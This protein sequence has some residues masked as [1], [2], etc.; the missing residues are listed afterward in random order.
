MLIKSL[1][2]GLTVRKKHP[3]V[4]FAIILLSLFYLCIDMLI[5]KKIKSNYRVLMPLMVDNILL[6]QRIF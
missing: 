2:G 6:K 3:G 5:G 4:L 1:L